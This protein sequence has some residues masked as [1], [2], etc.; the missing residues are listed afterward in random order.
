MNTSVLKKM[1]M[2][3]LKSLFIFMAFGCQIAFAQEFLKEKDLSSFKATDLSE[4]QL[5]QIQDELK[6]KQM[7]LDQVES[8]ALA[9]GI[10]Q[11]EFAK[12]KSRIQN[13]PQDNSNYFKQKKYDEQDYDKNTD[14]VIKLDR[15]KPQVY[16]S[17]LF[18][19]KSLSFEPNQNMPTPPNYILGPGDQLDIVL[20]G[21]QQF[22]T[23]S[24]ITKNGTV[25]I[26]NVGDVSVSGLTFEAA[27][28]KLKRQI[29]TIYTTL[30]SNS[31]KL[32]ATVSN[33]RTI[34]VTIIGARQSGNYRLSAMSTVYN[35]LHAAGGPND[36][37]SYRKI[38]L[39]RNNKVLRTIDLYRFL[40]KGDQ[41]DNLSL[42][43]NDVIRIPSYDGRVVLEGEVKNPGIYE[44]VP[45]E[46]LEEVITYASGFTEDAYKNRI[47]V[48][49]KTASELKVTD[50]N[51]KSYTSYKVN[52]GDVISVA[53]ILD[54]YENRVQIKGA[55]YRPGA[56]SLLPDQTLTLRDL[57]QKAD[58]LK[59]NVF[60]PKASLI[61]QKEDLTKEYI[62]I[63]LKA[64]MDG[65]ASANIPLKK[66]DVLV[67]FYNQELLDSY[68][69]SID[70]EVRAPGSYAYAK[71]KT[72][73]DLLL[74]S[75][76]FNDKAAGKVTIYRSKKSE[77]FDPNDKEKILSFELDL[78]PKKPELA[79]TFLLE[80]MD[81]VSVRRLVT[82]E[83]PEM[84]EVKGEVLYPGN[85]AIIKKGDRVSDI[86]QRA[87]G[88]KDEADIS[89]IKIIR[90]SEIAT[91]ELNKNKS[92]VPKTEDLEKMVK[93]ETDSNE[94]GYKK[95]VAKTDDM[96]KGAF[97][98]AGRAQD[99]ENDAFKKSGKNDDYENDAQDKEDSNVI[100][101]K[102]TTA[103][104]INEINVPVD[105]DLIKKNKNSPANIYLEPSD[106]IMVPKKKQTVLITGNVMFDTEVAYH[107]GKGISYYIKNA[108]G[109]TD[110]GWWKKTYVVYANGSASSSYDFLG[111]RTHPK[112]KPGSKI[113]VPEKPER[114]GTSV[115]EIVGIASVLTSLAGVLFAVFK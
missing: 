23:T 31:S 71:G 79:D 91:V 73:Y 93:E 70:G 66:E 75:E 26:P 53:A 30:A 28:T 64:V 114:K 45:N 41:S 34:L 20:Y 84:I 96:E 67:V 56:Y 77:N 15:R 32:S 50:L 102:K 106:V 87:G 97:K 6:A 115:G 82:F 61:R 98:K 38:E 11:E 18:I 101:L 19:S 17:E 24:T 3:F 92:K 58:G 4:T 22:T 33:Y 10:S 42:E 80:P 78:D 89:A 59:E 69:V 86:I 25:Y 49:Q 83:T 65:D 103:K 27:K 51:E 29:G 52:G 35:A 40:T 46:T 100:E 14:K 2:K 9:K 12:L 21:V 72:L 62:N 39:I 43:D 74:E 63:N 16:G 47:L 112:V 68:K 108:G 90:K 60:L 54:R 104:I 57:I 107:K 110:K 5:I 8:V 113:I 44:I 76:Y 7:T 48:K 88:F 95:T 109:V 36:I 81:R 37:G 85:Y 13:L 94:S 111:I 105:W 55:V 1:S 99:F